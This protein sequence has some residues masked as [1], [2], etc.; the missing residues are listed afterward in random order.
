MRTYWERSDWSSNNDELALCLDLGSVIHG[1]YATL[2]WILV[3]FGK[4]A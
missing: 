3:D 2:V 1:G 4:L